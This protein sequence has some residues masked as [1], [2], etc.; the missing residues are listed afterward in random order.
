MIPP[1]FN[2]ETNNPNRRL[3]ESS[4]SFIATDM[5]EQTVPNYLEGK[6]T[7]ALD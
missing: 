3:E 1:S 6:Q 7:T 4:H 2:K 5:Q